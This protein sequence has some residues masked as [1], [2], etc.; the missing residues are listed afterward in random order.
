MKRRPSTVR[1]RRVGAVLQS[2]DDGGEDGEHEGAVAA[3]AGAVAV[4]VA[5]TLGV[6]VEGQF[7]VGED[8]T[9]GGLGA[10]D[11]RLE[12]AEVGHYGD[13]GGGEVEGAAGG[14][15]GVDAGGDG[16]EIDVAPVWGD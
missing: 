2:L 10:G 9:P 4:V 7:F 12:A 15:E 16:R 1:I 8:G 5:D 6:V 14:E 11:L 3:G 13:V